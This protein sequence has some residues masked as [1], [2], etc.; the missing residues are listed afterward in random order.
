MLRITSH[1]NCQE[2]VV[3][4]R[5]GQEGVAVLWVVIGVAAIIAAFLIVTLQKSQTP[6]PVTSKV[7]DGS[8]TAPQPF[9][10]KL[11]NNVRVTYKVTTKEVTVPYGAGP[12]SSP[13]SQ[14]NPVPVENAVVVFKLAKGDATFSDNS[15]SKSVT[16]GSNGVASVTIKPAQDG[17]DT[18]TF[19]IEVITATSMFTRKTHTIPDTDSFQFEVDAP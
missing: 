19:E 1:A 11:D 5:R 9:P 14:T 17:G 8:I 13:T 16:T 3:V 7:Y 10:T 18:L 4:C 15:T 2:S 12:G 6:A